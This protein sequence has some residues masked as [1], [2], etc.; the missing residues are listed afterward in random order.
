MC[1]NLKKKH[2]KNT[3]NSSPD[4][5]SQSVQST[6]GSISYTV[7]NLNENGSHQRAKVYRTVSVPTWYE[8]TKNF[9]LYISNFHT[10]YLMLN[11]TY[12]CLTYFLLEIWKTDKSKHNNCF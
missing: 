10:S 6:R 11:V 7:S 9:P 2:S 5:L 1:S 4:N 8:I 12:F 3:T